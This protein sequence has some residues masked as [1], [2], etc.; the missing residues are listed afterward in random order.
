MKEEIIYEKGAMPP[1]G[2]IQKHTWAEN[3]IR[4]GLKQ[5]RCKKCRRYFFPQEMET[6]YHG[7][8]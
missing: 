6:H 3:Q 5:K 1:E 8:P 7:T 4:Q 2:Y